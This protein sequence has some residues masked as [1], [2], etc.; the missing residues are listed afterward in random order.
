MLDETDSTMAEARRRYSEL[1]GPT[2]ILAKQQTA[3]TGRRGR[4]W[5]M[6]EG[7][8]AATLFLPLRG[9]VPGHAALRSFVTSLALLEALREFVETRRLA[10][11]WPNDVL[12]DGGKLAG[13]LLESQADSSGLSALYIGVGV[14]LANA[15]DPSEV[16]EGAFRPVAL[17]VQ[18][19]PERFLDS[20][21]ACYARNEQHFAT[22]GFD[23]IRLEWLRYAARLGE[24]IT[25]RT[26]RD[27]YVGA[28]E[29]VGPNG[30]LILKT[31]EGRVSVPAG[32]VFF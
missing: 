21:T 11:K 27:S 31:G 22:F 18:V 7:N 3:A 12:L 1:T 10:L 16:E 4:P 5:S 26:M 14:N 23:P 9:E 25:A 13:I 30:N 17:D 8:F 20:L 29:T 32:D 19:E 28:F 2:W 24:V 6:P 15:P